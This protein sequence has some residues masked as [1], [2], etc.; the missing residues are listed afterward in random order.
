VTTA[1]AN[2]LQPFDLD[3]AADA[4]A[5]EAE[6]A[7]FTFTYKGESYI[8]PPSTSWPV[9]AFRDIAGG[10]LEAALVK[11]L[12]EAEFGKLADAGLRIGDLNVLF[13]EIGRRA[14]LRDLPNSP[15][16]ARRNSTPTPKR[17]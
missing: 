11:M 7:P 14:G 12:G 8:V 6:G 13:N 15:P 16:P 2:G 5:A 9:S 10:D 1:T 17:R 3:A 4:A